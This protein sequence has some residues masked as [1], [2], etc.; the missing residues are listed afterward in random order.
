MEYPSGLLIDGEWR[1]SDRRAEVRNRFDQS[2]VAQVHQAAEQDVEEAVAAAWRAS[3]KPLSPLKR[4]DV[5]METARLMESRR[6]L[7]VRTLIAEGGFTFKD[8]TNEVTRSLETLRLSAEEAKRIWGEF[9]PVNAHPGSENRMAFTMRMPVG[10]VCAIAPFNSPLNTLMHKVAPALAAGNAV[11]LKPAGYTPLT[12][13]LVC[14]AMLDAGLPPGYLNLVA[15]PGGQ[16][17]EQLLHDKRIRYYT[18]T[19]STAVGLRVKQVSGIAKVHLELG[20]NSAVIVREDADLDLAAQL[21][22]RAGFRKAGQ[23]CTS[24]Q[25]V[26][27]ERSVVG[28]LTERLVEKAAALVVGDPSH[29]KTDVGPMI[30]ESEAARAESWVKEA[31]ELGA[32]LLLGGRREGP[33]LWPTILGELPRSARLACD[34]VFA[35]VVGIIPVDGLDDAI[36][37]ANDTCYGLQA[38][39]FTRDLE[40]AMQA[41]QRLEV[42]GVMINDTSSYHADLAPYGGVKESGFGLE[43]PRYV[44]QDMTETR[45][46]VMNLGAKA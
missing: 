18:F 31:V 20:A 2:L 15:G 23:V 43:G 17:G 27:V 7:F 9:V 10:V 13:A 30:A 41:A 4:Y 25:R 22:V 3:R 14:Q 26:L 34:E 6:E 8:S 38:G 46:V 1:T 16:V 28:A 42:G 39:I 21:I 32:R 33:L 40:S 45:I 29:P 5:L 24:V 44:I 11:V 19:G 37:L 36:A 35:P 12:A